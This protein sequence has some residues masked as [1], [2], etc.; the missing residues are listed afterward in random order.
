MWRLAAATPRLK[1]EQ[2]G[3][4]YY[5]PQPQKCSVCHMPL[6][7]AADDGNIN[8][9]VHSHRVPGANTALPGANRSTSTS[10][11]TR[12]MTQATDRLP[13]A[14]PVPVRS[15]PTIEALTIGSGVLLFFFLG[16][17]AGPVAAPGLRWPSGQVGLTNVAAGQQ[18]TIQE[19]RGLGSARPFGK[20]ESKR[21]RD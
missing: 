8:G 1:L 9:F 6:V 2:S 20:K 17:P 19:G 16:L 10:P 3:S 5:P 13:V 7:P 14:L 12:Q 15:R 4:F 18:I 11:P 21:R